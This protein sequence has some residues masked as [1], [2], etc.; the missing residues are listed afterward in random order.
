[1]ASMD[2][3]AENERMIE[4][5]T[6]KLKSLSYSLGVSAEALSIG[7]GS[8]L[9]EDC[10][11]AVSLREKAEEE[12]EEVKSFIASYEEKT[13]MKNAAER[14]EKDVAVLDGQYAHGQAAGQGGGEH[15]AGG[16]HVVRRQ[17]APQ[18]KLQVGN[19]RRVVHNHLDRLD[20]KPGFV[21]VRPY[22][23]S[24]VCLVAP[25]GHEHTPAPLRRRFHLGRN[26]V[27]EEAVERHGKENV[28]VIHNAQCIMHNRATPCKINKKPA[29]YNKPG[30]L[31]IALKR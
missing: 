5:S 16:A 18:L 23:K 4:A 20:G 30:L 14:E 11:T 25:E 13:A 17:P 6:M 21:G 9:L 31:I 7:S 12:L 19:D 10:R 22:D 29:V 1:M 27:S 24:H 15:V 28:Y 2:L 8:R 3:E 26:G